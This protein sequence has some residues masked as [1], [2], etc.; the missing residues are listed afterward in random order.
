MK[1]YLVRL[2]ESEKVW[3]RALTTKG[4]APAYRIKH[5]NILLKADADGP[6]WADKRIAEAVGCHVRTV[7]NA[8]A[9]LIPT[10]EL[11]PPRDPPTGPVVVCQ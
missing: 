4:K 1:K 6:A 9:T 5:A 8:V 2:K 11:P 3:L 10:P 7:E